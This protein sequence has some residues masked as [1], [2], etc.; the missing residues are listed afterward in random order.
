MQRCPNAHEGS[1]TLVETLAD[2]FR[3]LVCETYFDQDGN[4]VDG[5]PK[6]TSRVT[7]NAAATAR[8]TLDRFNRQWT[9]KGSPGGKK[10][11]GV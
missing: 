7:E 10:R 5:G 1:A 8:E 9:R 11:K 4:K 2:R 6:W 3:C